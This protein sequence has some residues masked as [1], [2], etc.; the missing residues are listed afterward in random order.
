MHET[1]TKKEIYHYLT[2]LLLSQVGL[3]KQSGLLHS[4]EEAMQTEILL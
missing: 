1:H 2:L 4:L 3:P